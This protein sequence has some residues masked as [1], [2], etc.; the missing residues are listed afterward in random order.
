MNTITI[1]AWL[2]LATQA[3]TLLG[4]MVSIFLTIRNK[5]AIIEHSLRVDGALEKLLASNKIVD[6]AEG[7]AEAETGAAQKIVELAT[8]ARQAPR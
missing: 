5:R 1:G 6:K 4:L 7:K 3:M 8:K 2:I